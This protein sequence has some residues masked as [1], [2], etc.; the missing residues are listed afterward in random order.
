MWFVKSCKGD[1]RD[2]CEEHESEGGC[3]VHNV[4]PFQEIGF[5]YMMNLATFS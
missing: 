2:G 5:N 3:D 1:A 4:F